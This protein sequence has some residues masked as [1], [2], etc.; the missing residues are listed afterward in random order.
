MTSTTSLQGVE[1]DLTL[2]VSQNSHGMSFQAR[3]WEWLN[4]SEIAD[5][6]NDTA[7]LRNATSIAFGN[8]SVVAGEELAMGEHVGED[9]NSVAVAAS[10]I[11]TVNSVPI[12]ERDWRESRTTLM[13]LSP[14][15]QTSYSIGSNKQDGEPAMQTNMAS[16]APSIPSRSSAHGSVGSWKQSPTVKGSSSSDAVEDPQSA[17]TLGK[18]RASEDALDTDAGAKKSKIGRSTRSARAKKK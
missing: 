17:G 16:P 14:S 11:A 13:P 5:D 2:D 3:P 18:R 10:C 4:H 12:F 6:P 8:F 1:R 9:Q 15:H 7:A